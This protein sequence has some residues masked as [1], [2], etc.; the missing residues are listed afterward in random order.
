LNDL[1]HTKVWI[2]G[3]P[4]KEHGKEH[5]KLILMMTG[6]I[7]SS[8]EET[9]TKLTPD[10]RVTRSELEFQN[11]NLSEYM[12]ERHLLIEQKVEA[13][14]KMEDVR[15]KLKRSSQEDIVSLERKLEDYEDTIKIRH[16]EVGGIKKSLEMD[17]IEEGKIRHQ[18]NTEDI[19]KKKA[20]ILRNKMIL[21]QDA[22]Q[23]IADIYESF[24]NDMRQQIEKETQTIFNSLTWKESQFTNVQLQ[25]DYRLEVIDRWGTPA[26]EELS[27]GERQVL[28]LSFIAAM[29][30]VSGEEAPLVMDT[31]FGR[32]SSQHR[33]N[34][35]ANIPQLASQMI[36][37]ITDEELRDGS[38]KNLMKKVGEEYHLAFDD[39][40][41]CT[42]I[43]RSTDVRN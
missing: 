9:V 2:C 31:P 19:E 7:S 33:E 40:T 18:L 32:L 39:T 24:A 20:I 27:A 26:S 25:S 29:A 22:S 4:F 38:H 5:Q 34:I 42:T 37:F 17:E 35:T 15:N 3:R 23:A 12:L 28:S 14:A 30:K 43:D 21:A 8:V 6:S 10:L 1:I 16:E 11:K 41:G 36:L 13:Y